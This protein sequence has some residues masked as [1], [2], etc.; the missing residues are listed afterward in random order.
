MSKSFNTYRS[1][2]NSNIPKDYGNQKAF[3]FGIVLGKILSGLFWL[4]PIFTSIS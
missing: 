2:T 1:L 3:A 4:E